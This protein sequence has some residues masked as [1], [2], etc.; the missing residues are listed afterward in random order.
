MPGTGKT[1]VIAT[2]VRYLVSC[3]KSV[4]LTAYTHS[5]VDNILLKLIVGMIFTR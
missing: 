5:A 1:T 2:L 3:G 4:L